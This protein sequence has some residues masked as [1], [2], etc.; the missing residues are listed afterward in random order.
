M[1]KLLAISGSLRQGSINTKLLTAMAMAAPAGA[2]VT[3]FGGAGDL[4]LFNPDLEGRE[5]KSVLDYWRMLAE[6]DG[7]IIASPEY[8]HGYTGTIK[9]ALDWVVGN[10]GFVDKHVAVLNAAPR[11]SIAHST[12]IEVLK[13]IDAQI[14]RNASL[15]IPVLGRDLDMEG[16]LS[17]FELRPLIDQAF[18]ELLRAIGSTAGISSQH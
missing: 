3:L 2:M 7:V 6:S 9:N 17:D 13:T 4:P 12:L 15:D 16:L 14:V 18:I 5:P 10:G 1:I 8:A 11:S